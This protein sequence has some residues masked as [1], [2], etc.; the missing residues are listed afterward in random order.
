MKILRACIVSKTVSET[1]HGDDYLGHYYNLLPS[2]K[3]MDEYN[4]VYNCLFDSY[5]SN[6]D[7]Q[8]KDVRHHYNNEYLNEKVQAEREALEKRLNYFFSVN[9]QIIVVGDIKNKKFIIY[10]FYNKTKDLINIRKHSIINIFF[11]FAFYLIIWIIPISWIIFEVF[12][13]FCT[14]STRD[15]LVI[16]SALISIFFPC[17][18]FLKDILKT[19]KINNLLKK[20]DRMR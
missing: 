8:E 16:I 11:Y 20:H 17:F 13:T 3:V 18:K 14:I 2:I 10:A 1:K 5:L 19:R 7:I 15:N 12:C 9:D 6:L 4:I